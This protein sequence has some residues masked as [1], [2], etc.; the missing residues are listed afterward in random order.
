LIRYDILAVMRRVYDAAGDPAL[1][2][3]AAALIDIE[4]DPKY[5]KKYAT[6]W[7]RKV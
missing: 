7:R 1:A 5:R 6:V 3:L 2:S 4:E